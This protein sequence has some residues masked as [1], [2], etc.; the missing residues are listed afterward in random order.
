ME[1]A[2]N[3]HQNNSHGDNIISIK[4]IQNVFRPYDKVLSVGVDKKFLDDASD[5]LIR[6]GKLHLN[7][8]YINQVKQYL[9]DKRFCLIKAPEGRGKTY[10]SRIIAYD[11]HHNREMEVFF[12]D[13]KDYN[14]I[15]VNRIDDKLQEWHT[16]NQKDYL[17]VIENVHAYKES[18]ALR[19]LISGWINSTGNCFW[20]LLNSRPTDVELEEFSDWE[21]I[22]ELKPNKEDVNNI[23]N[24]FSNEVGREP[25][26]H[27]KER[28]IFVEQ[29]Y[30]EKKKASGANL[31]LLKIYLE[32]WQ[33]HNEIQFISGINE[34]T[35]IGE[36]RRL[37]LKHRSKE[38]IEAL[39]YIS[40]LFQFDV[41]LHEIFLQNV[42]N[43]VEDGLLRLEE[44]RYHL[45]HSVDASFL[46]KAI[47]SYKHMNYVDQMKIFATH[48]VEN[49][50]SNDNPKGFESDF[51][52]L[53]FGLLTRKDEFREVIYSLTC[54]NIAKRIISM[55]YPGFVL[56]FFRSE[57]H[58]ES[59]PDAIISYYQ[60]NKCWFI[61]SIQQLSPY[62]LHYV[63]RIFK[64]HLGYNIV[65]DIFDNIRN[66][67]DYLKANQN[68]K[69][70]IVPQLLIIIARLSAG[71]KT[72]LLEHYEK[73]RALLKP[74]LLGF[75]RI[76]LFFVFNAYKTYLSYDI[77]KDIF[78]DTKD[79]DDY[80]M[81][82]QN[83]LLLINSDLLRSLVKMG[84]GHNTILL[85]HYKKNKTLL[86]PLLLRFSPLK[87]TFFNAI[88]KNHLSYNIVNDIFEDTRVLDD[89]LRANQNYKLLNR[90]QV[91]IDIVKLGIDQK[92]ILLEHYEKNKALLKPL[93]L[94]C[95]P[96]HLSFVY[97]A[98]KNHLNINIV[99]D[100]FND[101]YD[102]ETYLKNK[103][104]GKAFQRDDVLRAIKVLGDKHKQL[105]D[106][107]NVFDTF[108]YTSKPTKD[109]F[110]LSPRYID[111]CRS[112][113]RTFDVSQ[114]KV[115]KFYLDGVSWAYLT[116]FVNV[117]KENMTE[118]NRQQS[119]SMVMAIIKT[120]LAKEN[121]LSCASA[122]DLGY[123]YYHTTSFDE[124]VFQDLKENKTIRTDIE[125]R[126]KASFYNM[127]DLYLFGLFF[128]ES[129]CKATLEPKLLNADNDQ[130]KIINAW[131]NKVVKK[132][133]KRGEAI[134]SGSLLDYIHRN[135]V[136]T[137]SI[138]GSD[139]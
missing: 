61:S 8:N 94:G 12:L 106:K 84:T 30:L 73:N 97:Q 93:F 62:I 24:L 60:N 18:E 54:E 103:N 17:L 22:V 37:Y 135:N 109:S 87:L 89:Y 79:L 32:T 88:F 49:I 126:L 117:I 129:W 69:V 83:Y 71:H 111:E 16:N 10:L 26:A 70:F 81:V 95:S 74:L 104:E 90:D 35:V 127:D 136:Y 52:L 23:I 123:F 98:Y 20:F 116:K 5:N 63:Y 40:S 122:K 99:K 7:E 67:D 115:N 112:K 9:D 31:R 107:Y 50:L 130:Q 82:N 110:R 3:I 121:T 72:I 27:D 131:Y 58:K 119:I 96:M 92:T 29:I 47:C 113:K 139:I 65:N 33:Y 120:V 137:S 133:E 1:G 86:K 118:E 45:P 114:I 100:I 13:L 15:T 51:K 38:E 108:I 75:S 42:G 56:E 68:Y 59:N 57:N 4:H 36:F 85:E 125:R 25:F 2:V 64:N 77:L 105:L 44:N 102:L 55:V 34:N 138:S 6:D 28:E 124:A 76:R 78:E 101:L 39:W 46:Y 66:L 11:Y 43:L 41:P 134:E 53:N 80:L 21:E 132:L 91:L 128:T 14:G 19:N 48:F